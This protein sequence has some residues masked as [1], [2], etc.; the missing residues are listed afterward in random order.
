MFVLY[1]LIWTLI[2]YWIHRI[3]HLVPVIQCYHMEHHR[4]IISN[5]VTWHWSNLFLYND[6]INS[7]IDL[8]LTEVIPTLIFSTLTGQLWILFFYYIWAAF[9]QE[10][11]EHNKNFNVPILTSGR[12]HLIHHYSKF[13]Y[14]M[15]TPIW[16]IIFNT[17]KKSNDIYK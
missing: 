3:V 7:T 9:I 10:S 14:G 2:L 15:F 4:H 6:N 5:E 12:W 17:Y 8:W 16:D 13:N 11:I 1:F